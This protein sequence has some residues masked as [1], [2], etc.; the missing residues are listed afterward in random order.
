[1]AAHGGFGFGKAMANQMIQQV[2]AAQLIKDAAN[3][4]KP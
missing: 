1:M 4:V 3:A 2:Q